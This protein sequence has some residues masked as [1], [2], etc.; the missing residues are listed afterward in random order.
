MLSVSG[1]D[2]VQAFDSPDSLAVE[3]ES[4]VLHVRGG[5][6]LCR[7]RGAARG[8][9]LFPVLLTEKRRIRGFCEMFATV[10]FQEDLGEAGVQLAKRHGVDSDFI[11]DRKFA[12]YST[13]ALHVLDLPVAASMLQTIGRVGAALDA[14]TAKRMRRYDADDF[15]VHEAPPSQLVVPGVSNV[16]VEVIPMISE[17]RLSVPSSLP[18]PSSRLYRTA[19]RSVD[20][21]GESDIIV[22]RH[23]AASV[24]MQTRVRQTILNVRAANFLRNQSQFM[25]SVIA[26]RDALEN[27]IHCDRTRVSAALK[28]VGQENSIVFYRRRIRID[29]VACLLTR[30]LFHQQPR[31]PVIMLQADRSPKFSFEVM[32]IHID[33]FSGGAETR[34]E[35]QLSGNTLR[36][37]N[38]GIGHMTFSLLW[39]LWLSYGPSMDRMRCVLRQI[40]CITSD[41]GLERNLCNVGDC[42]QAF[43]LLGLWMRSLSAAPDERARISV[44]SMR[45]GSRL[46]PRLEFDGSEDG[47]GNTRLGT[48]ASHVPAAMPVQDQGVSSHL[49]SILRDQW[50]LGLGS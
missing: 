9:R 2:V 36:H 5:N 13:A 47:G 41:R 49:G 28:G 15:V 10:R 48:N 45:L 27:Q 30:E 14:V 7:R 16:D 31:K 32:G 8:P 22:K 3:D 34:E 38:C 42:L 46:E 39:A 20:F 18:R 11:P 12:V 26:T 1:D 4:V 35:L 6:E 23:R 40:R 43:F 44:P 50:T 29:A 24:P 37:G 19:K 25:Q 33:S 21:G 17:S